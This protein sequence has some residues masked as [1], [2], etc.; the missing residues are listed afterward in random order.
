V[1]QQH[2]FASLNKTTCLKLLPLPMKGK[3]FEKTFVAFSSF[4]AYL[5]TSQVPC[6]Y[7]KAMMPE[8]RAVPSFDDFSEDPCVLGIPTPCG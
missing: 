8:L 3:G 4:H 2:L 1:Y 6:S 5:L 7:G